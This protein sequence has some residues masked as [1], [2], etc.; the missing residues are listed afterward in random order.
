MFTVP[1]NDLVAEATVGRAKDPRKTEIG[2]L[3]RSIGGNQ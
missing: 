1:R 3:E 2:E